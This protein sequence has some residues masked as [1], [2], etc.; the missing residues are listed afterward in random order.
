MSRRSESVVTYP[1]LSLVVLLSLAVACGAG[2]DTATVDPE[3]LPEG[4]DE[5]PELVSAVVIPIEPA[6]PQQAASS[7]ESDEVAPDESEAGPFQVGGDIERPRSLGDH[8]PIEGL[9]AMMR[10]GDYAWGVCIFQ[11]TI[12][13][14]GEVGD[15]D[16]LKPE[17]LAPEVREVITEAVQEWRFSPATRAGQP[18]PVYYNL[19]IHHCPYQR[20]RFDDG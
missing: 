13:E 18:V 4:P 3:P 1:T 9:T 16:F 20:T 14:K 19:L 7:E 10:S 8:L 12:S 6:E 15:V 11:V 2:H 17:D 5:P